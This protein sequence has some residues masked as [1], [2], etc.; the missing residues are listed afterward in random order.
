MTSKLSVIILN[1]NTAAYTEAVVKMLGR[2][3]QDVPL[4]ILVVDNGSR[5]EE[6]E[7]ARA[8]GRRV[9]LIENP[10]NVGFGTACNQA[11]KVAKGKYLFFLNNDVKIAPGSLKQLA[12]YLDS[13]QGLGAV[14]LNL[15]LPSGE[16]QEHA[17]G[18]FPTPRDILMRRWAD[19]CLVAEPELE[20]DWVAGTAF[21]V[22]KTVFDQIGGFD[23]KIF[24]Y[25]EDVDLCHR[26]KDAGYKNVVLPIAITHIG[27][28]S[29]KKTGK[30]KQLYDKG[31]D[32]YF[33]KY[34]PG[35]GA[36]VVKVA[37]WPYRLLKR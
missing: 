16:P 6:L 13:H 37:R 36:A 9:T 11:A 23:E 4:E 25:F 29:V 3:S 7:P 21:A 30:Q 22:N 10:K 26:L 5:P 2:E 33:S 1:F 19:N 20:V 31:M 35:L 27:G 24:F 32:Y 8:L 34:S 12:D 28:V 17:F 18:Q 14:S 15:R